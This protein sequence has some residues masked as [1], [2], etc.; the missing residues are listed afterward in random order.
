MPGSSSS[1]SYEKA[2]EVMAMATSVAASMML[3]R[4]LAN[5]L[6]PP[7]ARS[8]L[9][10]CLS[11][12]QSRMAWRHTIVVE[13]TD[14]YYTNNVFYSVKTYL[15]SRM[16]NDNATRDVQRL[17]LSSGGF[18]LDDEDDPEKLVLGM[19]EGEEMIEVYQGA[20]FRWSL[21][22]HDLPGD[23]S[24]TLGRGGGRQYYEL[25]FHKKHKE[26]AIKA[27]VPH[28]LATA[29]EIRDKD[30]PLTIYMN[31]GSDW[32]PMD[33]NHPSTFDTLAMDR[34]L[35]RSVIDD[36]DK[37]IKRKAYFKKIGKA[38]KRG[39][40]LHGPP[41]IG[42][43]SLIAAIAN[44]LRFDIYDLELTGVHSN[45]DL[46]KLLIGMTN[47]SVLVIEDI[48][49]TIDLKQ[50]DDDSNTSSSTTK[51]DNNKQVTLSGLLNIIDGLWSTSGEE[52]II[53]FTTNYKDRLDPALLRPGRMDMHVHMGYCT[54]EAFRIL[55]NNYHSIDYHAT[56]PQIEALMEE[57]EVTP[58]EV[59]ETLMRSEEPDVAL[60][61]LIELLKSKKELLAESATTSTDQEEDCDRAK[62]DE[63]DSDDAKDNSGDDDNEAES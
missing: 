34:T 44:H 17:R 41:G 30:R 42:K 27:Y 21:H 9:S 46:R 50:R 61:A 24:T 16:E 60:H 52:R 45:S 3:V 59:A 14:G 2:K 49:C 31:D 20:E 15:A 48:D 32:S 40:L 7:E 33:L 37:F 51:D 23:S 47:Q 55:V 53:V 13:K 22:S 58:A 57:V 8:L 1:A 25:T 56:Y 6:I 54:T 18:G 4:S 35:K 26:K 12:L 5:D 43:S 63:E 19:E 10:Y 39:Y 29:K 36:L 38:W 28:I 62:E 11:G